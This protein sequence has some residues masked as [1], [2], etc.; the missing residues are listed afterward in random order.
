MFSETNLTVYATRSSIPGPIA[1][2]S[3]S[4]PLPLT[5]SIRLVLNGQDAAHIAALS[6]HF[7]F[8]GSVLIVSNDFVIEALG[9]GIQFPLSAV[10]VAMDNRTTCRK[11][12]ALIDG[13]CSATI[14]MSFSIVYLSPSC[15]SDQILFM[16]SPGNATATWL[17]PVIRDING[18]EQASKSN[19]LPGSVFPL[20][21]TTV[22]YSLSRTLSF[23][24][25][26][27][28]TPICEFSV[29]QT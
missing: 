1:N 6:R 4:S 12:T 11:S 24:Q 25:L 17:P 29:G 14:S 9:V 10:I 19:F 16:N 8:E 3:A 18:K 15:P 2:I 27:A 13:P 26:K 23:S 5:F 28:T 20:G 21:V 7:S 22:V